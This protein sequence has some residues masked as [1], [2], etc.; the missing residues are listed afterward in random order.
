MV[1][2]LG[3]KY[4]ILDP[5][6]IVGGR[7]ISYKLEEAEIWHTPFYDDVHPIKQSIITLPESGYLIPLAW[8]EIVKPYLDLHQLSYKTLKTNSFNV[9]VQAIRVQSENVVFESSS[10]QG[11]Q[12]TYVTG[13]W[14]PHITTIQKGSIFVPINQAK[15]NLVAHLLEP[16]GPD[17]MSSWGLFNTAYEISDYVANH[18]AFELINWMNDEHNKI[19]ELYGEGTYQQLP[20]LKS[21]YEQKMLSDESFRVDPSARLNF[22]ISALPQQDLSLNL[23]P[24]F[25]AQSNTFK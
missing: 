7:H 8:A 21:E 19:K 15:S 18:R 9:Q 10:F 25:R 3:Y 16:K 20:K 24:I 22:W 4:D 11:R 5:A 14:G 1:D 23:Y 17:S 12:M 6:P 2:I 13:E